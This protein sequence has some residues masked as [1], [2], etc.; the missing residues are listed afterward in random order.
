[1][2]RE[3]QILEEH[4]CILGKQGKLGNL[5]DLYKALKIPI[6]FMPKPKPDESCMKSISFAFA[7][8]AF[9]QLFMLFIALL[10]FFVTRGNGE[11]ASWVVPGLSGPPTLAQRP[12]WLPVAVPILLRCGGDTTEVWRQGRAAVTT[13]RKFDARVVWAG[14]TF[15]IFVKGSYF[16][17]VGKRRT[18]LLFLSDNI[19][20]V[21]RFDQW[22]CWLSN[23]RDTSMYYL[24]SWRTY[25]LIKEQT[26]Q[27][28]LNKY[29]L[30]WALQAKI[31]DTYRID[32]LCI[33]WP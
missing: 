11:T 13:R 20:E 32:Y 16:I 30:K 4:M 24:C 26:E 1:M 9:H 29:W 10:I 17:H 12:S 23:T 22:L 19:S 25:L 18:A 27:K 6:L 31:T 28:P 21:D 3:L 7:R 15:V 33:K 8:F 14:T 5:S 2:F